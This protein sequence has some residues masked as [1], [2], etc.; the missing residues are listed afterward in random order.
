MY[1]KNIHC[2]C[3]PVPV[4][5]LPNTKERRMLPN[6]HK[7]G[8]QKRLT[9]VWH[10]AHL[11]VW[12]SWVKLTHRPPPPP[13]T[14]LCPRVWHACLGSLLLLPCSLIHLHVQMGECHVSAM[15]KHPT[16]KLRWEQLGSVVGTLHPSFLSLPGNRCCLRE[17]PPTTRCLNEYQTKTLAT[18]WVTRVNVGFSVV[19]YFSLSH[20]F[21]HWWLARCFTFWQGWKNKER[22]ETEG[23]KKQTVKVWELFLVSFFF[24]QKLLSVLTLLTQVFVH[25]WHQIT[26]STSALCAKISTVNYIW[27]LVSNWKHI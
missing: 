21:F 5:Q 7:Q 27:F 10:F 9:H 17:G 6:T 26:G 19:Y 3:T 24:F 11:K 16:N 4:E 15:T 20:L 2:L 18:R 25:L 13:R 1:W 14:S 12:Q 23:P 8:A 22:T